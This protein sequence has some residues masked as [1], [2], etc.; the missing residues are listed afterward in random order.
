MSTKPEDFQYEDFLV[1]REKFKLE[2]SQPGILK[3]VPIPSDLSSYYK[4]E[5]YISHTDKNG[6]LQER[7]YQF[8]KKLM[9]S[10]K[11]AWIEKE[12]Q[13][14]KLLDYGCGTGAFVQFMES[15]GWSSFGI[16]PDD[17][18]RSIAQK[19]SK[20]IYK[21]F[22]EVENEKYSVITLWHVLEHIPDYSHMLKNLIQI[23][24]PGG[25]LV[26]AVPNHKSYDAKFYKNNWAAWDVP[27]HLWHF[28]REGI[29]EELEN[30]F[31]VKMLKEKPLIFDSFYVSLLS[32]KHK[33]SSFPFLKAMK[34]GLMS[35]LSAI[36]SREYSSIAY[37]FQKP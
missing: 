24:Q 33:E 6:N 35:N 30:N 1:S 8:V 17:G 25:V 11:A 23:L 2:R 31:P 5:D 34:T 12:V 27:R 20:N 26:I 10:R 14:G 22:A 16:E 36:S 32:E 15:R 7:V 3:T 29:I 37:F 18:A 4:S 13:N 21:Y 19:K 28:S 9:L